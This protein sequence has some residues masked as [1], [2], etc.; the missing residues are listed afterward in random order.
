MAATGDNPSAVFIT[1]EGIEG[2]GKSTHLEFISGLLEEAGRRVVVTREPGGTPLGETIRESLLDRQNAG[3]ISDDTELLL[4]FA[5]RAQHLDTVIRPGLAQGISIISDR[6][7]DSSFAYQGGGRGIDMDRIR[8]LQQWLHADLKPDLTL[9]LDLPVE[10]GLARAGK[11]S[12]SDRFESE[13]VEFFTSVR[14]CY[15]Q[16]A[17]DEPDRFAVIDADRDVDAIRSDIRTVLSKRGMI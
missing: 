1:L 11:R 12:E 3:T 8:Q 15:L 16:L 5:A 6:F 4:M 17:A 7:T 10:T 14:E 2:A 13:A 9:L